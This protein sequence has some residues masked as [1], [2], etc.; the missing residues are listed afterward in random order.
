MH[1][2]PGDSGPKVQGP[3]TSYRAVASPAGL[4][5]M[6]KTAAILRSQRQQFGV[7]VLST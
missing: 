4:I 6:L 5:W 2:D 1:A 3:A 7:L